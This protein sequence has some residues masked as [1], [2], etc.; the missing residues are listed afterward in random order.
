[1]RSKARKHN[2]EVNLTG[3]GVSTAKHL[4]EIEERA[5]SLWGREVVEGLGEANLG[6]GEVTPTT[7]RPPTSRPTTS[8][9]STSPTGP[10]TP[11]DI[12]AS[13]IPRR[14]SKKSALQRQLLKESDDSIIKAI[15]DLGAT[16]S[17]AIDR[18]CEFVEQIMEK[19][20]ELL[21]LVI[22]RIM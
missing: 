12:P 9:H 5:L 2:A 14:F 7:S 10:T 15:D 1:M 3:G 16:I 8:T 6:F 17:Q 19:N 18:R 11:E 22:N 13:R 4:T 21:S 20:L